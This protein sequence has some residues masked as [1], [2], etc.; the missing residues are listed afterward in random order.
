MLQSMGLE[1]S[2]SLFGFSFLEGL[3]AFVSPCILPMLPIYLMYLGGAEG[4]TLSRRRL[5]SNTLG[6]ITGFSLVFV[7]L[8]ATASALGALLVAHRVLLQRISGLVVIVFGLNYLGVFQVAFL[9]RSK[10]FS[11]ET[12]NLKFWSSTL[13]GAAFSFG[14]TPCLGAFLGTALLLASNAKTLYQGMGLLLVFSLGLAI[15]F[16]LTAILWSRLQSAFGFI[17]RNMRLIR[18][19]SGALLVLVGILMLFDRF[20]GYARLFLD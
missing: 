15:P 2:L 17:K 9:N 6:F 13:F 14:W 18:G 12:K 16:F 8:G 5:L 20:G 19:I 7:A 11:V 1:I 3:L 10:T 4:E